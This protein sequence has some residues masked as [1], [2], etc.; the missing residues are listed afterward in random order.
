M[1]KT[2]ETGVGGDENYGEFAQK[3]DVPEEIYLEIKDNFLNS[4]KVK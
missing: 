3:P 1:R 2:I 4:L